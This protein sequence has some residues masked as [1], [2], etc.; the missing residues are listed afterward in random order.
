MNIPAIWRSG[1]TTHS[2]IHLRETPLQFG[3][4]L[5][6]Y[7]KRKKIRLL[8]KDSRFLVLTSELSE[9]FRTRM[10]P[11]AGMIMLGVI[12]CASMNLLPVYIAALL[13]ALAMVFT[14]CVRGNEVYKLIEWR[15]IILLG[16]ASPWLSYGRIWSC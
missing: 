2:N 5:L 16:D 8:E 11:I 10:A 7:G 6:V 12:L 15:V 3:D 9:V 14:G 4:A 1:E 13:G